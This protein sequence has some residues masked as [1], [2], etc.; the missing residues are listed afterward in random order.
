MQFDQLKRRDILSL[1]GGAAVWP[2]VARA[3]QPAGPLRRIGI[4][5]PYAEGDAE[6]TAR[7]RALRQELERLGWKEGANVQF[8]ERWTT[9]NMDRIRA[10]AA[11]LLASNPDVVVTT[12]GRVVPILM[13]LSRSVPIVLPGT[14]DP[15]GTGWV[16]GL[17]RPGGNVTGFTALELPMFGKI[18]ETLKQIA[19]AT[20]RV[21]L[22][23]NPDN[24][25][26]IVFKRTIDTFADQLAVEPVDLPIHKLADI[27][28]A[29][30]SLADGPNA[31]IFFLPDL[32]VNALRAEV[33]ALAERRRLPAMY[34][35]AIFVKSGGLAFYGADRIDLYRRA[36]GYVDRILHG[37]K[38]GE[39]PFQ[40]PTKYEL[41]INLK[42]AKGLGLELSPA[43]LALADEV[44]E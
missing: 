32:T 5:M 31:S 8:D 28:L 40:Q 30:A 36:A 24:P 39:L 7:V 29:L 14:V 22:I 19:P 11:S 37:A 1:L 34:S 42:A 41:M 21:G 2:L 10:N 16:E 18:L 33:I 43:L 35:D 6:Y 13:Q 4:L 12:G 25:T 17:A 27:E 38:P 23:Y 20:T 15:V 3:Q 9:D 44:I 26:S